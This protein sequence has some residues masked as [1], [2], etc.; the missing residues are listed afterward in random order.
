M[1]AAPM[2]LL[3]GWSLNM[4]ALIKAVHCHQPS[5]PF[6]P[7][8]LWLKPSVPFAQLT[9]RPGCWLIWMT[10]IWFALL[11]PLRMVLLISQLLLGA[12][13]CG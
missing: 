11:R 6:P 8:L 3:V 13:G 9:H 2:T 4:L 1:L 10:P 12:W 5:T 7:V